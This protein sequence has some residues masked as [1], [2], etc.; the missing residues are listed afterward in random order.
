MVSWAAAKAGGMAVKWT[1]EGRRVVRPWKATAGMTAIAGAASHT[2][3]GVGSAS[4]RLTHLIA[5][6]VIV[7]PPYTSPNQ[8]HQSHKEFTYLASLVR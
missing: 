5:N 4:N 1:A 3:P 8:V 7:V 2:A 6:W